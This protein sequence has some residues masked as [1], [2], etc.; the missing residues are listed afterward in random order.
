MAAVF[1]ALFAAAILV[2]GASRR[3]RQ[4]RPTPTTC[5]GP[6]GTSCRC[7]SCSSTSRARSNWWQRRSCRGCSSAAMFAL[8]FL[9]RG[10]QRHPWALGRRG[11]TIGPRARRPGGRRP[12][13]AGP[14]RCA[15]AVR[16]QRLGPPVDRRVPAGRG[17]ADDLQPVSR[18]RRAGIAGRATRG[19]AATTTGCCST[20]PIRWRSP[21]APARTSSAFAPVLDG[22]QARAVLAYLRRLRA[23]GTAP[24]VAAGHRRA[25]PNPGHALRR[26][27]HH[28]RGRRHDRAGPDPHRRAPR[29]RGHPPDRHRSERRVR[30]LDDAGLRPAAESRGDRRAGRLPGRA[31]VGGR[32]ACQRAGVRCRHPSRAAS[33]PW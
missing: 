18:R 7:S 21:R 24:A 20:W 27:P 6:S 11:F 29:Q 30:R 3:D 26:L 4:S 8:P 14:A 13:L 12:D 17:R 32:R 2:P 31:Q 10:V 1:A 19:S 5:R 25:A 15:G 9:D 16:S 22:D 23:G 33:S 28:R